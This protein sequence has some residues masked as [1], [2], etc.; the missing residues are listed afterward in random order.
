MLKMKPYKNQL[1]RFIRIIA[2]LILVSG[3]AGMLFSLSYLFSSNMTDVLGAGM[4]FIAR[5]ILISGGLIAL[6][7]LRSNRNKSSTD[8]LAI[9]N[10]IF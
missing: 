7:N 2:L 4:A 9:F 1:N 6:S 10:F 3:V 8:L 5:G